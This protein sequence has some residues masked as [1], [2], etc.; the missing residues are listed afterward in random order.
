MMALLVNARSSAKHI[1]ESF[2]LEVN[3]AVGS[4]G[5]G[6]LGLGQLVVKVG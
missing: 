1:E 4:L 6:V 3:V 2:G 5:L